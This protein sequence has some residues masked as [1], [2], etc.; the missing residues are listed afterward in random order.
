MK[1]DEMLKGKKVAVLDESDIIEEKII[2]VPDS[3][4]AN[5]KASESK[6]DD[7]DKPQIVSHKPG[8]TNSGRLEKNEAGTDDS[9]ESDSADKS[10]DADK[11]EEVI[12][13]APKKNRI[14][15]LNPIIKTDDDSKDDATK[16]D[17]DIAEN[18]DSTNNE[19]DS[20]VDEKTTK[21]ENSAN[22]E[23]EDI[24]S[25]INDVS[26][27]VTTKKQA[28]ADEEKKVQ[29]AIERQA[30]IEKLIENKHFFV[31]INSAQKRRYRRVLVLIGLLLAVFVG[32]LV[33]A[34]AE[35]IDIG[36]TPLTDFL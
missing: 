24:S 2:D 28:K 14:E 29:Q 17:E 31:T 23:E 12:M 9:S 10:N 22:Q 8:A 3:S 36:I 18:S 6:K 4:D 26:S 20:K 11:P 21:P 16:N 19:D 27:G 34:D 30:E 32:V 5:K 35:M 13:K 7:S 25:E 1:D 15:P 33:A